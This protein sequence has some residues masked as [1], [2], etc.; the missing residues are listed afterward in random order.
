MIT[1]LL[2]TDEQL[3]GEVRGIVAV[4]DAT[5]IG[6]AELAVERDLDA[7][8][9]VRCSG[10]LTDL[11]EGQVVTLAG[12]W[13]EHPRFGRTFEAVWYEQLV[14]EPLAG[15]RAFLAT[16]GF[17]TVPVRIRDRVLTTF[18]AGAGR[19]IE[20]DPD[21][22]IAQA[23]LSAA[24]ARRLHAAWTA[25]PTLAAWV[26][27]VEPASWPIEAV[28][29]AHARFGT[30]TLAVARHDA[31]RLLEADRVR[32]AHVDRLAR[33]LGVERTD[34][35]RLRAGAIATVTAARHRQGHEYLSRDVCVAAS[36]RLLGVDRLL[37]DD[38]LVGA[39]AFG[40]LATEWI[41]EAEVVST[42]AA[43]LAEHALAADITRLMTNDAARRPTP[44]DDVD[45]VDD[46]VG[47]G[48]ADDIGD[49]TGPIDGQADAVR[50]A[51]RHP[52]SVV[53]G[54]PGTARIRTI[55][56]IVEVAEAASLAVALVAPTDRAADRLAERLRRSV[57][58]VDRLLDTRPDPDAAVVSDDGPNRWLPQDL[59]VI[60]AASS[61]DTALAA[62]LLDAVDDRTRLVWVGDADLPPSVGPGEVLRE[63]VRSEAIEVTTLC[64]IDPAATPSRL[65]ELA[66]EVRSGQVGA[67]RGVDGD[68]FLAEE[69]ASGALVARVVRAVT[70]RIP[71][72]FALDREQIQVLSPVHEGL[73]GV[74]ALNAGLEQ[75]GDPGGAIA[76][77]QAR[78]RAWPVV[79]LVLDDTHR[80]VLS[81]DLVYSAVTR[82]ERALIVIGQAE[83]LRAAA[84]VEPR[85][86]RRTGLAR[87]IRTAVT[88]PAGQ[89]VGP[90]GTG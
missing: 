12:G 51:F 89:A 80:A 36:A 35:R 57:T 49:T 43:L 69:S 10:P 76:I 21:R 39:V 32:F 88:T 46:V 61:C 3:I 59:I 5:G 17:A 72:Y 27:F 75:A 85:G 8:P 70:E 23:G 28:R 71:A 6:V 67:L 50:A 84:R 1:R 2:A 29:S 87:R 83:T 58:T 15:L 47:A 34:P 20:H 90:E 63:L 78:D 60:A 25:T 18:G 9:G 26:A 62:R 16:D 86:S 30:D 14:P 77:H 68:V 54:G 82:A 48:G 11:A 44:F 53:T 55:E 13:R 33:R 74:D 41:G 24:E 37:A 66:R 19:V 73:A 7:G 79:V 4:E 81:R 45:D 40:A 64:E 52:V 42:P 38:G 31:Y 65:V 56:R 22:L